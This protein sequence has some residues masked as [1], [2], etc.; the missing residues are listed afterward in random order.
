MFYEL[1]APNT[2]YPPRRPE[3]DATIQA[4][5]RTDTW[6]GTLLEIGGGVGHFLSRL[7]ARGWPPEQMHALEYSSV[8]LHALQQ[9]GVKSSSQALHELAA[10]GAR[11][12]VVSMF[13]VLEHMSELESVFAALRRLVREGGRLFLAVPNGAR[14]QQCEE[15]GLTYDMPPNHIGRWRP[16]SFEALCSRL[17]WHI[18]DLV[19][20]REPRMRTARQA[21]ASRYLR[22]VGDG[23]VWATQVAH[24]GRGLPR[25]TQRML[26]GAAAA[27]DWSCWRAGLR[28]ALGPV[29]QPSL[30][31]HLTPA[32]RPRDGDTR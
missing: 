9:M 25:E 14:V 12:D 10:T 24:L 23:A 11:F 6:G 31:L 3:F 30:W 18:E 7:I 29:C 15:S 2:R 20:I 16:A 22:Q 4:L 17:S 8:A 13:H 5:Q 1:A 21:F 32:H 28:V 26:K 19:P 27:L